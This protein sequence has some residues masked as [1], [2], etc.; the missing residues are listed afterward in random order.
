MSRDTRRRL[1][2]IAS[3]V[4]GWPSMPRD[5]VDVT[6]TPAQAVE[7]IASTIMDLTER[8]AVLAALPEITTDNFAE[9]ARRIRR[10][11]DALP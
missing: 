8:A 2:E 10:A 6:T 11:A 5:S 4:E 3:A 9:A 7:Y 1:I